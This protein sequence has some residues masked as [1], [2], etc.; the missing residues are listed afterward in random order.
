MWYV[1]VAEKL[2][3]QVFVCC[4][5]HF[6]RICFACI[7]MTFYCWLLLC[8][9]FQWVFVLFCF[10]G[11]GIV[12]H[13]EPIPT[14][15]KSRQRKKTQRPIA[16]ST[17][18]MSCSVE[19]LLYVQVYQGREPRTSTSTLTQLLNYENMEVG[20]RGRLYTYRYTDC[21]HQNDSCIKMGSD[22][23]HLMFQQEMTDKV[24]RQCPQTTNLLKRKESRSGIEPR[25]FRLP[26]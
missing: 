21:H 9:F 20:G 22:E 23:S 12:I 5:C 16:V 8:V 2:K 15:A 13:R 19:V 6:L 4:C 14:S 10:L 17:E 3:S 24:T 11:F 26:A 25:S 1:I 18:I 7:S